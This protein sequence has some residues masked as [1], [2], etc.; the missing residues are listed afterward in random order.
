[1]GLDGAPF[2]CY[3]VAAESR[4]YATPRFSAIPVTPAAPLVLV[5]RPDVFELHGLGDALMLLEGDAVEGNR[6][7]DLK[8]GK[9]TVISQS[10]RL[11]ATDRGTQ[12]DVERAWSMSHWCVLR[13]A[14]A[15]YI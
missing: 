13:C 1:M 10:S 3:W 11:H 5:R 4:W 2:L 7:V 14:A 9:Y 8:Q 6:Y 15:D 12:D